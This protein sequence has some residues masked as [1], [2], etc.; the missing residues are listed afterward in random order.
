MNKRQFGAGFWMAALAVAVAGVGTVWAEDAGT[1]DAPLTLARHKLA[2]AGNGAEIRIAP[3][4]G[5]P[6]GFRIRTEGNKTVIEAGSGAGALYGVDALLKS[7]FESGRVEK[8]DFDIRG[9]TLPL[10]TGGGAYI[11]TLSPKTFPWFFDKEFMIRALDTFADARLNTIFAWAGHI[12]PYIVEMPDYPEAAADVPPEQI[13]ANQEQFLWFT[14]ECEKRNIRV[15]VHF[16][17]IHVS[18]P[19]AKHHSMKTNPHKPTPL[20]EEYTRYALTRYF[21]TFPAVGLYACPGESLESKSQLNWFR[22]VIFDAAKKSGKN[23]V[24]VVRDWTLNANFRAQLKSLYDNVYSELKHNDESFTSPYPD[25]RHLHLEGLAA[26]HIVNVHGPAMDF[27]PM[28]WASPLAIQEAAQC[29]RRLGFVRGVEFFGTSFWAWPVSG[30]K[31]GK[32]EPRLLSLDRDAPY[33]AVFGRYLWR[34][35]RPEDAE[36]AY[37][38]EF[39]ARRFGSKEIGERIARWYEISGSISPGIQNLNATQVANYW[40][41]VLLMN[42]KLDQILTFNKRLDDVPYTL[43]REAGRAAQ[44]YYPRPYDRYFFERYRQEHGLPKPGEN[45]A[46]YNDFEPYKQRMQIKDIAQRHCMPVSQY[47]EY[48]ER[49]EEVAGALTPDRVIRLLHKMAQEALELARA[50]VAAGATGPHTDELERF[51][52]D[53]ELYVLATQAMIHKE[54]AAILKARMLLSKKTDTADEFLREME[55]S[56]AVYEQLS[57]LTDGTYHWANDLRPGQRWSYQGL[58]EFRKDLADQKT[59][60]EAFTAETAK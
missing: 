56:V 36:R 46:M 14:T 31:V 52:T 37:W 28:R 17:I 18:P 12:F 15:L 11:S 58:A 2:G 27:Q 21:E 20:L 54:D 25:V 53:G 13:K 3:A 29:W 34:S 4:I 59:W 42:Q 41:S 48:L 30:D 51:V 24:I 50:A 1:N 35:D 9:T 43:H 8:P 32:G 19:F 26:G 60:I 57:K 23:P 16:Y 38:K 5:H 45:A 39:Y 49:G 40:A 33:Y 22:D 10:M 7:D 47:A 55:Q 44:R 6:E